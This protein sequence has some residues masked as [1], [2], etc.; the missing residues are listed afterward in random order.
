M[1]EEEKKKKHNY[2]G[3]KE[4]KAGEVR[5]EDEGGIVPYSFGEFQRDF[6]WMMDRFQ[7]E[8]EDFWEMPSRWRHGMRWRHGFPMLPFGETMMPS[9]DLEI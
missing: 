3:K 6:E 8:F 7:R 5:K 4:K 9:V 1:A 2:Y